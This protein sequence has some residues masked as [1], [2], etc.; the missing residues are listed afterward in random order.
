MAEE[1]ITRK[2]ITVLDS[3]AR[4]IRPASGAKELTREQAG[5]KEALQNLIVRSSRDTGLF[6]NL[7]M[8]GFL[9]VLLKVRDDVQ[10]GA[11]PAPVETPAAVRQNDGEVDSG[12]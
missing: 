12:R 7:F 3:F 8:P 5:L 6:R 9:E 4:A 11:E 10:H 2:R 1:S